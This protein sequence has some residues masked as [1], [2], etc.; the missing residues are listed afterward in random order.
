MYALNAAAG[1]GWP[2]T[3]KGTVALE[4]GGIAVCAS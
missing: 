3:F 4:Y 2:M 1:G